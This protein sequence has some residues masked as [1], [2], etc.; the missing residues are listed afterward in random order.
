MTQND[1]AA[2]ILD[3]MC[4]GVI[5]CNFDPSTQSAQVVF[6]NRGWTEITGYSQSQLTL[7]KEGNPQSLILPEDK[8]RTDA[9][10]AAQ[11]RTSGEYE[12]MYRIVHRSGQIRWVI[13]K[14]SV[15]ALPDATLQ[16]LSTVTEV[17]KIKEQEE[18]L[19]LL[20]QTDQLTE[21]N[22]K[23]TFA[24]MAQTIL[25]RQHNKRH[26]LLMVDIDGFKNVN[27]RFG[28][29]SGDRVLEA[30]AAQ[31]KE[32]F[33]SRDVLG[34]IGGDE[35]MILMTDLPDCETATRKANALCETICH[36]Q[37]PGQ[38]S[39]TVSIGVAFSAPDKPYD[40][41]FDEVDDA[42]YRAKNSGKN[43]C[44]QYQGDK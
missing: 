21:L 18:R 1:K 28:H 31:L 9:E 14:G 7:E 36:L 33:R 30:V 22:N 44:Q 12:L 16:N 35:F 13:D 15:T 37:I 4:G 25:S 32:Q 38:P 6:A 11:M 8:A 39:V 10:Y 27:D 26:A 5:L 23:T 19:R 3:Q 41:F 2:V 24:T 20:A 17:T 42:L 34:R 43:Q 29:A 40:I